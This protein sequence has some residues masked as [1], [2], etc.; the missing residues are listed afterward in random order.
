MANS[1]SG[2]LAIDSIQ[3]IGIVAHE[4]A[5]AVFNGETDI[6]VS[7]AVAV[8]E[9]IFH[10]KACPDGSVKFPRGNHINAHILLCHKLIHPLDAQC[11]A[12]IQRA[13][14]CGQVLL[15]GILIFPAAVTD[16]SF[17]HKHQ[18]RAVFLDQLCGIV[19]TENQMAQGIN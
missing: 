3:L 15:H 19:T 6:R 8:E 18:G 17:I 16:Q 10:G 2:G 13:G 1:F 4:V 7:L 14:A 5:D 11:F 9:G 12:G